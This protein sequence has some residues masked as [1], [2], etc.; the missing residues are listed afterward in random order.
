[1]LHSRLVMDIL[2]PCVG[3]IFSVIFFLRYHK[4]LFHFRPFSSLH[5]I[6]PTTDELLSCLKHAP[7][8]DFMTIKTQD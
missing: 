3:K 7:K 2:L 5:G 4:L 1:M 6:R 8:Y